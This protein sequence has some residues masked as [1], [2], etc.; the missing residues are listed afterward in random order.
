MIRI[1]F[2]NEQK[3][4]WETELSSKVE[5]ALRK[6]ENNKLPGNDGLIKTLYEVFGLKYKAPL[7]KTFL[8]VFLYRI[9][10]FTKA[11]C[12]KSHRIKR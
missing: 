12:Y 1:S 11:R 9:K 7:L 10:Y 2:Y 5:E 6:M 4:K 3:E 8:I